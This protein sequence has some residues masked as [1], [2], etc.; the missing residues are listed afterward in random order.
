M[1]MPSHTEGTQR[2]LASLG[3]GIRHLTGF[4]IVCKIL[5][6]GASE[7]LGAFCLFQ[8]CIYANDAGARFCLLYDRFPTSDG[9]MDDLVS[10][11][12]LC[13]SVCWSA[14]FYYHKARHFIVLA[15][16][17]DGTCQCWSLR[18]TMYHWEGRL[19]GT[20]S[21]PRSICVIRGPP[22]GRTTCYYMEIRRTLGIKARLRLSNLPGYWALWGRQCSPICRQP[23]PPHLPATGRI[24]SLHCSE[25]SAEDMRQVMDA[26]KASLLLMMRFLLMNS[27]QVRG[28]R[29]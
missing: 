19:S 11:S 10:G 9:H 15:A 20:S 26:S 29:T 28:G 6:G 8:R 22:A 24:D 4:G 14:A 21:V 2:F 3:G 27:L 13:P 18:V 17:L 5:L 7:D 16:P 25:W 23:S 1:H 12:N